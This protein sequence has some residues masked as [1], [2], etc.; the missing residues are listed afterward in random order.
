[1]KL[2]EVKVA[3][4][5]SALYNVGMVLLELEYI[6]RKECLAIGCGN[7]RGRGVDKS[8]SGCPL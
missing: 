6:E 3:I 5:I 1:L 8:D 7:M 4:M 2:D